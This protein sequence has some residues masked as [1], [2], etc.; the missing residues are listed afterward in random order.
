MQGAEAMASSRWAADSCGVKVLG[1]AAG[2]LG[3]S[4]GGIGLL[5]S[6]R[7]FTAGGT[8][9]VSSGG[10]IGRNRNGGLQVSTLPMVA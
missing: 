1:V 9:E 2:F 10:V 4:L 3:G 5:W 6:L 7:S 8:C